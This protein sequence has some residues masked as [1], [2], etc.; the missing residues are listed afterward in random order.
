MVSK[1]SSGIK[2]AVILGGSK[3]LGYATAAKLARQG[4]GICIVHRD[5]RNDMRDIEQGFSALKRDATAFC[6]FNA[7]AVNPQKRV[8]VIESL[9]SKFQNGDRV[10]VLVHSIAKGSVKPMRTENGPVL[11]AQDIEITFRAMALS[12]YE[13]VQDLVSRDVIDPDMRIISFTSEGNT[14]AMPG[15]AAVSVAKVAL[16]AL[17]RSIAL[18]FA[19]LGIKAN[20]LQAGVVDT[21]SFRRIPHSDQIRQ[22]AEKRNPMGRITTPEDVANAV[23]ILCQ[24]ESAWINGSVIKVDG[25]ES[26][27]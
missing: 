12:L 17:T 15:Y 11:S 19:P 6:S 1:S 3:G 14:R 5:R 4:Y 20:C 8:E 26:L 27:R 2:W 23:S 25:G 7:D 9:Q 18:E 16:E 13:W 10:K 21:E 22:R 24:D